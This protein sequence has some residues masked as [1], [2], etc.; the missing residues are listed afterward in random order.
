MTL[1]D[2]NHG[3]IALGYAGQVPGNRRA[4][5]VARS[6]VREAAHVVAT[7]GVWTVVAGFLLIGGIGVAGFVF[8]PV[9]VPA[10]LLVML[11]WLATVAGAAAAVRRRRA[12]VVLGYV[13]QAVRLNQPLGPL[14][15]AASAAEPRTAARRLTDLREALAGG[16]SVA[17]AVT[18]AVPEVAPADLA[19]LAHAETIGRLPTALG[20]LVGRSA[21]G[22]GVDREAR[23]FAEAYPPVMLVVV[24]VC[25]GLLNVFVMPKFSQIFHDFRIELP[26]VTRAV[27]GLGD[28]L[29]VLAVVAAIALVVRTATLLRRASRGGHSSWLWRG[30]LDRVRWYTPVWGA[31]HRDRTLAELCDGVADGL[32]QGLP[33]ERAVRETARLDLNRVLAGRAAA[34]AARLGGGADPATA[35]T[36]AR[37]PPLLAGLLATGA[38]TGDGVGPLRFAGRFYASRLQTRRAV[39]SAVYVPLVTVT[40]GVLVA[41]VA[42]AILL[43]I[44]EL[45]SQTGPYKVGW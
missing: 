18:V 27:V 25:V 34:W 32:E 22:N 35:A 13:E 40:L 44:C 1:T 20:R 23:A 7:A 21:R 11:L 42:L 8:G 12:T 4:R 28:G 19:R 17:D 38:A 36:A 26:P 6:P 10:G 43:P 30:P 37:L 2:N 29:V 3:P 31:I 15:L 24:L 14:L 45:V 33:L 39:L 5:R 41:A 9:L 16:L